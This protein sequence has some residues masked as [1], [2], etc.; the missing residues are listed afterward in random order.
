MYNQFASQAVSRARWL[1]ELSAALD[2]AQILLSQL[3]DE[4]I[5]RADAD[6]LRT[7]V[8]ELRNQLRSLHRG[9]FL[10]H[11][12][13]VGPHLLQPDWRPG[14]I[15]PLPPARPRPRTVP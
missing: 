1:A 13:I 10:P 8:V 12:P 9:G 11:Q 2:E 14:G 6:L 4:R 15:R 3:V 7:Q 5:D